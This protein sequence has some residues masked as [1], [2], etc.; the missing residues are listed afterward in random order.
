M[1]FTHHIGIIVLASS[2]A[3]GILQLLQPVTGIDGTELIAL[4]VEYGGGTEDLHKAKNHRCRHI[5]GL[6]GY[7]RPVFLAKNRCWR[8]ELL[9]WVNIQDRTCFASD[10]WRCTGGWQIVRPGVVLCFFVLRVGFFSPEFFTQPTPTTL[11]LFIYIVLHRKVLLLH[12]C[13][14]RRSAE[15]TPECT[16]QSGCCPDVDPFFVL[17]CIVLYECEFECNTTCVLN[18]EGASPAVRKTTINDC[19]RLWVRTACSVMLVVRARVS[20]YSI[21]KMVFH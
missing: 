2:C 11:L 6:C 20:F 3:A 13:K 1:C 16:A 19:W 10:D 7:L 18:E 8:V 14:N 21:R 9:L 15:K 17:H 5:C 12:R 4:H